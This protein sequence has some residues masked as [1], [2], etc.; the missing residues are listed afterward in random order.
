MN[1]G[2]RM[3]GQFERNKDTV[4]EV[5][6]S[7]AQHVGNIAQIIGDAVVKIAREVGDTITDAIE[8]REAAQRAQADEDRDAREV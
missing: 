5:T 1:L 7:V 4:Q 8:M 6:E 3:V 2:V